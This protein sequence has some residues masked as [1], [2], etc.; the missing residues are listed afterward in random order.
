MCLRQHGTFFFGDVLRSA[1]NI[2][3]SMKN[4]REEA[5]VLSSTRAAQPGAPG[6]LGIC[7]CKKHRTN[8]LNS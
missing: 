8:E 1:Q 2:T 5:K 4:L 7:K 3:K 6:S